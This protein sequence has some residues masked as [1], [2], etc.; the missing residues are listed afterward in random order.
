MMGEIIRSQPERFLEFVPILISVLTMGEEDATR[1]RAGT[2]WA[3]GRLGDVMPR[4]VQ[5]AIPW[6]I[7]CLKSSDPQTRGMAAWC[8]VQLGASEQ[9]VSHEALLEDEG[10]VDTYADSQLVSTCVRDLAR[11]ALQPGKRSK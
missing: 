4:A 2:L 11:A 5:S 10:P 8:L 9:L 7:P 3:I 6:I 1:F